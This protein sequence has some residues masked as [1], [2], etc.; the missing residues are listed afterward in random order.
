MMAVGNGDASPTEAEHPADNCVIHSTC[1]VGRYRVF[2]HKLAL[3]IARLPVS[4]NPPIDVDCECR[5]ANTLHADVETPTPSSI[6]ALISTP[7]LT[8]ARVVP[9]PQPIYSPV[10]NLAGNANT[11]SIDIISHGFIS[12]PS[13]TSNRNPQF[14]TIQIFWLSI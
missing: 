8:P 13:Y 11:S 2:V 6:S 7:R 1:V 14:T 12:V 5:T 4:K 3:S 9:T 10:P